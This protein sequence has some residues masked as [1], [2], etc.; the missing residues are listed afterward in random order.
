MCACGAPYELFDSELA[1]YTPGVGLLDAD[2]LQRVR[3][4]A[5]IGWGLQRV[6]SLRP[7]VAAKVLLLW[8]AL[9]GLIRYI[10]SKPLSSFTLTSF[11]PDLTS[12]VTFALLEIDMSR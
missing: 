8:N 6:T 11:S 7:A 10:C 4:G 5:L 3:C 1:F 12:A 2:W 9:R